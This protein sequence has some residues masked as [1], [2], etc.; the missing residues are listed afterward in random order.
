M[1]LIGGYLL[2]IV[3]LFSV[4]FALLAGNFKLTN[5]KVI[6]FSLIAS[7]ISFAL[8]SISQSFNNLNFLLNNFSYLFL[9]AAVIIFAIML[10]Y[11]RKNNIKNTICAVIAL[12]VILAICLSSQS[13]LMLFDSLVYS[14]L[15]FIFLFFVYQLTKLLVHAKRPYPIIVSEYMTLLS[16]LMLIFGLTYYSTLNLDYNMFEPFLILTPT[17]KLIYFVIG[18][19]VVMVI[20]V[21]L[22]DTK[23]GNA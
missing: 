13:K 3:I 14:L 8:I 10:F 12:Y 22:N 23:G 21:L 5:F 4:N 16:I 2:V 20:G 15:M 17:Y 11:I 1:D 19:C 18:I 9:M 7:I 6:I